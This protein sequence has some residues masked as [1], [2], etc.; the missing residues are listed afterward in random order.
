[1]AE[2]SLHSGIVSPK[3]VWWKRAGKQEMRWVKIAFVWCLI[4][5]G[6]MPVW[7]LSGGQ[8]PSGIRAKVEP[9]V[10]AARVQ[11]FIDEYR[12]GEENG[13]PVVAPPPGSDIYLLA[14]MWQWTPVIKLQ[15][16]A[17]Y[18]LHL[19]SSDVNHGFSLLPV[20]ANVQVVPGYDYGLRVVPN[21]AGVYEVVCNELCGIGHH[22]MVGKI[23]VEEVAP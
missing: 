5:F 21:E 19:S 2:H 6:M 22:I 10:Y 16:G 3:G 7:H 12:V 18:T 11:R 17:E 13:I 15:K 4:L 14:K 1:M 23:I 9:S 20:N 8:N